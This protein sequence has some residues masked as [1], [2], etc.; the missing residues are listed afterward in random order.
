MWLERTQK[1]K[2]IPARGGE[3]HKYRMSE[4]NTL[5]D[6]TPIVSFEDA[7]EFLEK[8]ATLPCSSCG[9]HEW[10]V[11]TS[12]EAKSSWG[13]MGIVG[14][15]LNTGNILSKAIPVIVATCKKCAYLKLHNFTDISK[16]AAGGKPE[17]E[18]KPATDDE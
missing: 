17:F 16:W 12:Q 8:R 6:G 4:N 13:A 3:Q 14:L 18:D 1:Q 9:H 2:I 5:P 15:Q 7:V 10:S 11:F